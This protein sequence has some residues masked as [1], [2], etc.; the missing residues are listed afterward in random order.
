M[1][2]ETESYVFAS[3]LKYILLCCIRY[4]FAHRNLSFIFADQFLVPLFKLKYWN[5]CIFCQQ[6]VT[7]FTT[8]RQQNK[9]MLDLSLV[10]ATNSTSTFEVKP[11]SHT[12][13]SFKSDN[14]FTQF[15]WADKITYFIFF[16]NWRNFP[17]T[18]LTLSGKHTSVSCIK[19]ALDNFSLIPKFFFKKVEIFISLEA[20][21]Y[22]GGFTL[23]MTGYAPACTKSVEMGIFLNIRRCRRLLQ[24]GCIFR[25]ISQFRGTKMSRA[26]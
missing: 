25:C 22:P 5:Y 17:T 26:V 7:L 10:M 3:D 19:G 12:S 13:V 14:E 1:Y 21:T 15:N 24:K 18:C 6:V 2:F 8:V 11:S 16:Q 20:Y 4:N 23:H 9:I